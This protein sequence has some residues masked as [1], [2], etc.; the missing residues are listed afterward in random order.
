MGKLSIFYALNV[1]LGGSYGHDINPVKINKLVRFYGAPI[2]N[3][4]RSYVNGHLYWIWDETTSNDKKIRK[5]EIYYTYIL[6]TKAVYKINKNLLI[7]KKGRVGYD[8][9]DKFSLIWDVMCHN[10]NALKEIVW[11]DLC[12]D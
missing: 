7:I 10:V 9:E 12:K 4:C 3:G 6:K 5:K 1:L 11:L 2:N 8:A